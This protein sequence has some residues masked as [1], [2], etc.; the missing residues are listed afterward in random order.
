MQKCLRK[1]PDQR[2]QTARELCDELDRWRRGEPIVSRPISTWERTVRWAKREP[3]VAALIAAVIST[4]MLGFV[5][6][7][8]FWMSA[9]QQQHRRAIDKADSLETAVA[10]GVPL[11]IEDLRSSSF[12]SAVVPDKGQMDGSFKRIR[13][14]HW[15]GIVSFGYR[16][17]Q[18]RRTRRS[19]GRHLTED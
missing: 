4:V 11:I 12:K 14:A 2:F 7:T 5:L 6:S 15:D 17:C 8:F 13:V 3:I 19:V 10:A 1:D 18:S 16:G 9:R